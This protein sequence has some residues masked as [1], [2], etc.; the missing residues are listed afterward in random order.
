MCRWT[1]FRWAKCSG[2]V[3]KNQYPKGWAECVK[4]KITLWKAG[5]NEKY[6]RLDKI[7]SNFGYGTRK[8]IKAMIKRA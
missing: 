5:R 1:Y 2:G 8:E 3:I 7:V 4:L 6:K